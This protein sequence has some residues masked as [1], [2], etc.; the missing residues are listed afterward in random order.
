[1]LSEGAAELVG[2]TLKPEQIE[3]MEAMVEGVM[4][5]CDCP[6][7]FTGR[8][9]VSLDLVEQGGLTVHNLD[10]TPQ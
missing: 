9:T 10:G 3:S 7:D 2:K 4:A 5:V 6:E 8:V 1:V